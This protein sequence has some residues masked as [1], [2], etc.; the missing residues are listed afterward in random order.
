M[1]VLPFKIPKTTD[2]TFLYQRDES[3][4]LYNKLHQHEDIQISYIQHGEGSLLVSDAIIE[5]EAGDVLI[6][7]S[8][9]PHVFKSEIKIYHESK[10]SVMHSIFF[11][12]KSIESNLLKL[13]ECKQLLE[14]IE[15]SKNGFKISQN[16]TDLKKLFLKFAVSEELNRFVVFL[17]IINTINKAPKNILSNF[18]YNKRFKD[19]EGKRLQLVYEF[20]LNNLDR[21]I[22]LEEV[23]NIANMTRNSF[24]KYF[25]VRTNKSFFQFLIELR[26]EKATKLLANQLDTPINE[27]A[28]SCGFASMSHFN[29]KFKLLKGCAPL[30]YRK[31]FQAS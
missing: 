26:I 29:N 23:A 10:P 12:E 15:E 9:L 27:I 1:K 5:Y 31:Q 19:S 16:A 28:D 22:T 3:V 25:K 18:S 7:G 21:S 11:S 4:I 24:C 14:F 2:E 8:Y 13:P 6:L 20:A 17:K 30:A